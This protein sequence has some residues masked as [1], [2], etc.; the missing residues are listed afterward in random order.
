MLNQS[1]SALARVSR[2]LTQLEK[3]D[4]EGWVVVSLTGI[5]VSIGL[6]AISLPAAFKGDT[7]HC[8][9]TVSR[10]LAMGLFVLLALVNTYLVT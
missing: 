1:E 9:I 2:Q 6:L 3:R 10:L 5:L 8:E 7:I 4:W